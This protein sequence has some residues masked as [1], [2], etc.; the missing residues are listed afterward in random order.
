MAASAQADEP[1]RTWLEKLTAVLAASKADEWAARSDALARRIVAF[2]KAMDFRILYNSA[3]HLFSIG[4]NESAGRL[5]NSHYDLLA[6]EACLTSFLAVARG[7]APRKHWFQLNRSLTPVPGGISLISWGGTMFEYLMPRLFILPVVGT[8]LDE[9]WLGA[10]RKQIDYSAENHVPWGVSESGFNALDSQL[11]YQYQAFGVPG[12]GAE[13]RPGRKRPG[14][15]TYAT[16]LALPV[17]PQEARQ[18]LHRLRKEKAL[19]AYGFY[20]AIDYTRDRLK[21]RRRS[22][23]IRSFMAHHQGMA[24][25][26]INNCLRGEPMPRRF[27]ADPLVRASDLLLQER[28]PTVVPLAA[29]PEEDLPRMGSQEPTAL[30]SRRI[31][32]AE[33]PHPRVHLLSNG[34]YSVMISNSGA[35]YSTWRN[36]D[37]TRWREDRVRD[38]HGQFFYVRDVQSNRTWSVGRHPLGASPELYEVVFSPDKAD[39][40]RVD[41]G[42]E[43]HLEITVCPESDAEVRR[44]TLTNHGTQVRELEVTSYAE[45]VLLPHGTD[46]AHPSFGKL[47]LETEFVREH[48]AIL[49]RRRPRSADQQ[50][51]WALHVLAVE[52][53]STGQTEYETDRARFLGRGRGPDNPV[54]L[55]PHVSLSGATGPVLDPI[56]S[57]RRRVRIDP[58]GSASLAFT[59]AVAAS[60]DE[61]LALADQYDHFHGVTRAFELA[62]AHSQV[63]LRHLHVNAEELHLYQR[64]AAHVIYAGVA[65][66]HAPSVA[67]NRLGQ[68]QLWRFGISGDLPIVLLRLAEQ[69]DL[70]LVRLMLRAH[71]YWRIKGLRVVLVLLND[72]P[73]SYL[74]ALNE[75]VQ[76]LIR[77]SDDHGWENKS[78]GVFLLRAPHLEEEER[79]LLQAVSRVVLEGR[80]GS[81]TSQIDRQPEAL[82]LPARFIP[83]LPLKPGKLAPPRLAKKDD[84]DIPPTKDLQF[85]NGR[86]GFSPDGREYVI[87]VKDKDDL[88]PA[89]WANVVANRNFGFPGFWSQEAPVSPGPATASEFRFDGGM[90]QRPGHRSG[91]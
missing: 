63:E 20:E 30:V 26:A 25:I 85:W 71:G 51:I 59:T 69:E 43:A 83:R 6:S 90:E 62:W 77:T 70:T 46:V 37:V 8:L 11:N 78:G 75:Q 40:R 12:S 91:R 49:C 13:T 55:A 87:L 32:S 31:T 14:G 60:R 4:Y 80:Q 81:L 27:H 53:T 56:F 10:V 21:K 64:L 29:P 3:R 19:A 57:L 73:A 22:A 65:L 9:C 45:V 84:R 58:G 54:A 44:L 88:P 16:M 74:E 52:G 33:T 2:E 68:Q 34:R 86:G 82:P 1:T 79:T 61:A 39:L 24:L 15:G 50:P 76:T 48:N 23:I 72:H 18:N 47:F 41:S 7:E 38:C 89:P 42:I 66:R 17:L 5:D 28:V 35:G 67:R 36:L